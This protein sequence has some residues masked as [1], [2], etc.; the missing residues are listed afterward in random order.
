MFEWLLEGAR[1]VL[2]GFVMGLV[3][4][5]GIFVGSILMHLIGG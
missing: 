3:F 4:F 1:D 5:V 2:K